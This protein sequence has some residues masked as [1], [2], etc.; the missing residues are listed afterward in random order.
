MGRFDSVKHRFILIL[1]I[2]LA[3]MLMLVASQMYHTSRLIELN[4]Q[5]A[6]LLNLSNGLLQLRR[7]E[8]DFLLRHNDIYLEKFRNRSEHFSQGL[9]DLLPVLQA[10][11]LPEEMGQEIIGKFS[12]YH[13]LFFALAQLQIK[14]G[15]DEDSGEMGN[16]RLAAHQLEDEFNRIGKPEWLV[17][18]LQLRR[19]EKD[20][21]Q[22]RRNEYIKKAE[23]MYDNLSVELRRSDLANREHLGE[24]LEVYMSG[25]NALAASFRE[26]GLHHEAGLQGRFRTQTHMVEDSLF[27]VE[28]RLKPIIHLEEER[29]RINGLV[30]MLLTS[31]ILIFLIVRSFT[32]FQRT[33]RAFLN[34]FQSSKQEL[35]Q[36]DPEAIGFAEFKNMASLANEMV[37]ARND[38]EQKLTAAREELAEVNNNLEQRLEDGMSEIVSLNEEIENTQ[39]EVVFT[40]G[41]I[42]ETRSKETGNHVRRVAEYS[43]LLALKVGLPEAEAELLKQASPMHDI[44]K[45]AIPDAILNKKGRLTED[46]MAVMK[47]HAQIGYEMLCHSERPILKAAAIVAGQH[48]EKWD[49]TGYPRGLAGQDIHIF[50]RITML[51]DVFDALGSRRCYKEPWPDEDIFRYLRENSGRMFDPQL[52]KLFFEHLE[53][54]FAIRERYQD[55]AGEEL[56]QPETLQISS[57]QKATQVA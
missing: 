20:F 12:N 42:G 35:R 5:S 47:T 4:Q 10:H 2:C 28:S 33:L 26:M 15:L 6:L 18:L 38:V 11:R 48:H 53:A 19:H 39:R 23:R 49:G 36:L 14:I 13:D 34:F 21:M 27:Q 41:A 44:G 1:A 22:R 55:A 57:D 56:A 32:T 31:G 54:F 29:V 16:F 40:M 51:A 45:V 50:G 52:V 25:L 30:I 46:E 24:L 3:G 8:K 17:L 43:K 37:E 9:N 7:N